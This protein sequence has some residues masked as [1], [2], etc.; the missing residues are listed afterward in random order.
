MVRY[1]MSRIV[2]MLP[3]IF[4]LVFLVVA[5]VQLIPGNIIDLMLADSPN[6]TLQTREALVHELGMDKSIA[7]R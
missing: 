2:G 5:M 7:V 4:L 3:S 1:V 6:P